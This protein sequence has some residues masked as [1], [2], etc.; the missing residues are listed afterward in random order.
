MN[1]EETSLA[2]G[3]PNELDDPINSLLVVINKLV[4]IE[5]TMDY[6]GGKIEEIQDNLH[7]IIDLL[8]KSKK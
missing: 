6:R 7:G 1:N 8:E 5:S 3:R 4:D 2:I